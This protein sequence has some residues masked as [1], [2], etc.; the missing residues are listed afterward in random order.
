MNIE[1][2][3]ELFHSRLKETIAPENLKQWCGRTG[4]PLSTITGAAQRKTVP[5]AATLVDIAKH[6]GRSVDWLLGLSEGGAAPT[7]QVT[8]TD[9]SDDWADFVRIPI[10]DVQASAG[11]GSFAPGQEKVWKYLCFRHDFLSK[12]L[13][14]TKNHL[15]CVRVRGVS[16]EP[17]LRNGHPVLIDPNDTEILTE[18][19]HFLRLEGALLLKNL[20]RLPGGR[21]RIWSENQTS[22][23]YRD[24]EMDWPARDGVDLHIF[25]RIRW[26]D[27]TF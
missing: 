17:V 25:G 3:A 18:G 16:M 14:I 19:P 2:L 23:T 27:Q 20:Q 15:Y 13:R 4:I 1:T 10:Y 11:H 5:G 22:K 9:A 21:L 7:A 12:E 26:S 8:Y 6:T 24:I